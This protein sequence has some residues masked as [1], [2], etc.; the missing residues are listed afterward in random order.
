M[1]RFVVSAT[2]GAVLAAILMGGAG[3]AYA[4]DALRAR[5]RDRLKDGSCQVAAVKTPA[6][7]R[8]RLKDGSC[9]VGA[10]K[11]PVRDRDRLKDGSCQVAGDQNAG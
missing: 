8:D 10:V 4:A 11:T 6:R 3:T 1:K 9:Q 2:A 7:D 5:D